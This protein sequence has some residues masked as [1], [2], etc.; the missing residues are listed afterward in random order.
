MAVQA[1]FKTNRK[2]EILGFSLLLLAAILFLCLASYDV[3]D[4]AAHT[5]AP[6]NPVRN[7]AG[8]IGAYAAEAL[9]FT[10]G[11]AAYLLP[12]V[13][14]F[15]A[16][17]TFWGKTANDIYLKIC[18][19]AMMLVSIGALARMLDLSFQDSRFAAGGIMGV[20]AADFLI[21]LFGSIGAPMVALTFLIIS[22]LLTT[23]FFVFSLS[24]I[25]G[26]ATG[27]ILFKASKLAY[28]RISQRD[29]FP[30]GL[31]VAIRKKPPKA[32]KT[33]KRLTKEEKS[34]IK[35][36]KRA[37][38]KAI[39]SKPS[40]PLIRRKTEKPKRQSAARRK[41]RQPA[42]WKPGEFRL[43]SM[44][45]L[46]TART[47]NHR[48]RNQALAEM[49]ELLENT[50]ATFKIEAEV[51]EISS[52]PAVT[53][54]ELKL[55][56]GIKV[57]KILALS[58]DLAYALEAYRVRIEAPIPGKSAVGIEVPNKVRDNVCLREVIDSEQF[59]DS[60]SKLTIALGKTVT[61]DPLVAD[62]AGMPHLLIAGATGSG[63]T[64]CVNSLIASIL[65]NC[66]PEE[67][68]FMMIDPKVVELSPYNGIPHLLWPVITDP[69]EAGKYL[70]WL[71]GEMEQRYK[72]LAKAGA[73]NIESYNQKVRERLSIGPATSG[74]AEPD[75][76]GNAEGEPL[77][78]LPYIVTIIDELADLM[79]VASIEVE[80]AITRLA[81]LARAVGIHLVLATQRP[82]VDVI[83]GVIKANFPARISFQVSSRVDSRTVLDMNGAEKLI[84]NGDLLYLP[85][86][87]AKPIRS[88]GV[89][90]TDQEITN[91]VEFLTK[92]GD[93]EYLDPE[94][95]QLDQAIKRPKAADD[96]GDP[97]YDDA[98]RVVLNTQQASS[99]MLQ[100]RMRVGYARAARL[101]DMMELDGIVGPSQ[102]SQ[103]REILVGPDY[104]LSLNEES[105]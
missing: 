90:I 22:L 6:N 98:V 48:N 11:I 4:T 39:E 81:Q 68:R 93:A 2:A 8:M 101:I 74:P 3:M 96:H 91:I 92:Q 103:A 5:S 100:R 1:M 99:S 14:L 57:N 42:G 17:N 84:G 29:E 50:L 43:P 51:V 52:G 60:R 73:R 32:E 78:P 36:K 21:D 46:D 58:D 88:Q 97:L 82:S 7:L 16:W 18:G 27:K 76:F 87:L 89:F 9:L 79:M 59:H 53:R 37:T 85:A 41:S 63:K 71:V 65:F 26:K 24:V 94:Q 64:V 25:V 40:K 28:E 10:V 86:G 15:W 23:E 45:L 19:L 20:Y 61:G 13:V 80:D 62:L 47:V 75:L 95:E 105:E 31:S 70:H 102:G 67:V 54:F 33:A 72:I 35:L 104:L 34:A 69:K 55:A 44:S 30:G 77:K 38:R 66:T 83:T 56:P 49:S 12:P